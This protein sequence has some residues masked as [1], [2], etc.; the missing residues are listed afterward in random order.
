ML[1]ITWVDTNLPMS[2]KSDY[3]RST[4]PISELVVAA[5]GEAKNRPALVY[6]FSGKM[7]EERRAGDEGRLLGDADLGAASRFFTF[8]RIDIDDVP[9]A[10]V[11]ELAK[12]IP[13]F[14]LLDGEGHEV[15]KLQGVVPAKALLG[16]LG[17]LY[18]L[19]YKDT[20]NRRIQLLSRFFNEFQTVE[21]EL[22]FARMDL[23]KA[24]ER[25]AKKDS[26]SARK[27]LAKAKDRVATAEAELK[28]LN[29]QREE[30]LSPPLRAPKGDRAN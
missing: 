15:K 14:L 4:L 7:D 30:L 1:E 10:D 2:T 12:K 11:K 9:E 17:K 19:K 21:D 29:A 13:A 26:A 24:E 28:E 20:L 27:A 22:A 16:N 18:R 6:L 3:G 5:S 23:E 8:F 25:Q